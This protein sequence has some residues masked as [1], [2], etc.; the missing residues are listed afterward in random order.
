MF[1]GSGC[2]GSNGSAF[3]DDGFEIGECESGSVS[4]CYSDPISDESGEGYCLEGLRECVGGSW[5]E[6]RLDESHR[7][8]LL[9]DPELC[10]G[11]DPR[12]FRFLDAPTGRDMGE[13]NALNLRFDL[14]RDGLVMGG[15][16]LRVHWAYFA[17]SGSGTVS[18]IDPGQFSGG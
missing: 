14:D 18:K 9:G 13:S 10:G 1:V 6:C 16:Q 5:S 7:L 3:V 12:C 15:G 4:V 2:S 11:C 8:P 17:N